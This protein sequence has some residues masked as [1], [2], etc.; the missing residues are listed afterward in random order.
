M[1]DKY[2]K[3]LWE[4]PEHKLSEKEIN[5]SLRS[6]LKRVERYETTL[7]KAKKPIAGCYRLL[8]VAG[9]LLL[10]VLAS[11]LTYYYTFQSAPRQKVYVPNIEY[12]VLPGEKKELILADGTCV[13]LNSGSVL[14]APEEFIDNKRLVY[15]MGEAYFKVAKDTAKA[16]IVRTP[17]LDI[18]ALGTAF[19]VTAYQQANQVRTTLTEGKV[20]LSVPGSTTIQPAL[21]YPSEQSYYDPS[22]KE[23][24]ITKVNAD[25]Y[26]SWKDGQFIFDETSFAEV[27]NRLK[28]Q[29]GCDIICDKRL[30]DVRITAK[31]IHGESVIDILDTLKEVVEFTYKKENKTIYI[32]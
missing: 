3:E 7:K 30:H 8:K 29:S 16:F 13:C 2:L 22:L 17:L 25:I 1:D 21:L 23:I 19:S 24:K 32:K 15:L 28:I 4:H 9:M 5:D 12:T 14:V 10:P 18:Q 6:L 20:L 11:Y 31:F 26:T 27:V